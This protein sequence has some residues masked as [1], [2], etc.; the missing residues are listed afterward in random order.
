MA[1]ALLALNAGSSSLKFALYRIGGADRLARTA[2]GQIEGIGTAP[3]LT[4]RDAAGE[5]CFEHRWPDGARLG[6]EVL[7]GELFGRIER[8][9][10]GERL[11]AVGHRIVHGGDEFVRPAALTEA[12][13][14]RLDEL[15]ALAPLHQPHNLAAV[16][17][18][19]AARPH[20]PQIGCFDTAFHHKMPAAAR[21]FGLPASVA[22]ADIRRYG[23]HGLS[24]EYIAGELATLASDLERVV[25]AHLG[26]GASL[27][28]LRGGRSIDTTMSLTPLDGLL[29]GTRCGALDPGVV[30]Y[31]LRRGMSAD[32]VEDLLYHR[33]GL[34][35]V[36]GF[37]SD[38]RELLASPGSEA[39]AAIE[40]FVYRCARETAALAASLGGLDAIVF[41]AGIGEH[42]PAIRAA[43]AERLAWLGIEIDAAENARNATR[44]G[45]PESRVAV[46]V[47]PTDEQLM[48]ARHTLAAIEKAG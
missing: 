45:T 44:I 26:N 31:L 19:A 32:E 10:G 11:V 12:V 46:L 41:T 29:M 22:G 35:G 38:M 16:R 23:F 3:H 30:L 2:T 27:C 36:S 17:A 15:V 1:D 5:A 4:A 40:L 6:H 33:S 34:F 37:S 42:A 24:Y 28:A 20:L 8:L 7:F 9:L 25:V 14:R 48:I 47:V 13:L 21:R 43:V 18:V 39:K